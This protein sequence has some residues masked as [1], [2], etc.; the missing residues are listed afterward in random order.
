DIYM[1]L[2]ERATMEEALKKLRA[3]KKIYPSEA[4]FLLIEI[5]RARELYRHLAGKGIVVRDRSKQ[6]RNALRITIGTPKQ[7]ETLIQNIKAFYE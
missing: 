7:N 4:N 2:R 6:V 5:D 1:I 3:V